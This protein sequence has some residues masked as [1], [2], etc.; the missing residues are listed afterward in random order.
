MVYFA[1]VSSKT[2]AWT[3]T[4]MGEGVFVSVVGVGGDGLGGESGSE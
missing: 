3:A 4:V 2:W 1:L